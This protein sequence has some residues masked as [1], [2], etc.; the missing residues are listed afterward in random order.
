MKKLN[1]LCIDDQREILAAL[2]KD[3][4]FII[5]YCEIIDCESAEEAF[6]VLDEMDAMGEEPALIICDHIMP[7][8][9][10]IDFLTEIYQDM[11]FT[12]HQTLLLTGLATHEDTITA[13]NQAHVD[14]Y[15]E[16]PWDKD[17]LIKS[18]QILLTFYLVRSGLDYEPYLFIMDQPTLYREVR[19]K[20]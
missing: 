2:R 7:G 12:Q 14:R 9:N 8:E 18:V 15:I 16:K 19:G 11:R 6:E 10:G 4:N 17:H 13:I 20:V 5:D 1:I 3:L